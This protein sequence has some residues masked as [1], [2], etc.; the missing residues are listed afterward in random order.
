M[1]PMILI[2]GSLNFMLEIQAQDYEL[3][4]GKRKNAV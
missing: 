2:L 3:F 4:K 1:M